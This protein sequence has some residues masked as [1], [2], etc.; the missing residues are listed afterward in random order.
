MLAFQI[1]IL[2]L[3]NMR[4]TFSAAT[5]NES[6]KTLSNKF[7]KEIEEK[8]K[9]SKFTKVQKTYDMKTKYLT[10]EE[11]IDCRFVTFQS[12]LQTPKNENCNISS[13]STSSQQKIDNEI[14]EN[15]SSQENFIDDLSIV[16][17]IEMDVISNKHSNDSSVFS[18]HKRHIYPKDS[19]ILTDSI[20]NE[21]PSISVADFDAEFRKNY[22]EAHDILCKNDKIVSEKSKCKMLSNEIVFSEKHNCLID[23]NYYMLCESY[24]STDKIQILM[25]SSENI[26]E[27]KLAANIADCKM[28]YA[29]IN[30]CDFDL[31]KY[32]NTKNDKKKRH[33]DHCYAKKLTNIIEEYTISTSKIG[34]ARP[35][36]KKN[37]KIKYNDK[38]DE[39]ESETFISSLG[40]HLKPKKSKID[41]LKKKEISKTSKKDNLFSKAMKTKV[42]KK[43]NLIQKKAIMP[44][45]YVSLRKNY[46][47]KNSDSSIL[48]KEIVKTVSKFRTKRSKNYIRNKQNKNIKK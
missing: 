46:D 33:V 45:N 27:K 30:P 35:N 32:P 44:I 48:S 41:N 14:F 2:Y 20:L 4:A 5:I 7:E 39:K 13:S 23:H 15:Q 3:K 6:T 37:L 12:N 19:E 18:E 47:F 17:E 26:R 22:R 36:N 40:E 25:D 10:S 29:V 38:I 16:D 42:A 31:D 9:N 34:K 43:G 28:K 1:I 8:I 21:H 24:D 11:G